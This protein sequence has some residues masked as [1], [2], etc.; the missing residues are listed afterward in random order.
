MKTYITNIENKW[1]VFKGDANSNTVY[2]IGNDSREARQNG[3]SAFT[4]RWTD[5]GI[6]YVASASPSRA[7]AYNKARRNGEYGGEV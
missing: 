3:G 4:A 2:S 6:K 1:Y 7:A 5:A